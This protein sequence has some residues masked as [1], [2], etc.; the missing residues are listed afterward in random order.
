MLDNQGREIVNSRLVLP[1]AFRLKG[2]APRR[3][4]FDRG[5]SLTAAEALDW[6]ERATEGSCPICGRHWYE[7]SGGALQLDH[8]HETGKPRALLCDACN[9]GLGFFQDKAELLRKAADYL[10][11]FVV[12]PQPDDGISTISMSHP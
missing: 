5:I 8:D 3:R 12:Q 7:S 11:S 6:S 9:K 1:V 2:L 4:R 10:E